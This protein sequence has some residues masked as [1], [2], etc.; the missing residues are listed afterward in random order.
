MEPSLSTRPMGNRTTRFSIGLKRAQKSN[1]APQSSAISSTPS[2]PSTLA[3]N[4][5][6]RSSEAYSSE[7]IQIEFK[8]KEIET[9]RQKLILAI[10]NFPLIQYEHFYGLKND[11]DI[12]RETLLHE[13]H[14]NQNDKNSSNSQNEED[15]LQEQSV[16]MIAQVE[17]AEQAFRK[18]VDEDRNIFVLDNDLI[19]DID[20]ERKNVEKFFRSQNNKLDKKSVEKFMQMYDDK[21]RQIENKY[22][23]YKCVEF[24]LFRNRLT[25]RSMSGDPIEMKTSVIINIIVWVLENV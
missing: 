18:R 9:L 13:M 7:K 23:D 3:T 22:N 6:T 17:A 11:I 20:D 14:S 12:R 5:T 24:D 21:L 19:K 10:E 8:L 15:D 1:E 2:H 25:S 4:M 16:K